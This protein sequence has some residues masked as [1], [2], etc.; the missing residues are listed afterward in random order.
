MGSQAES[1][2]RNDRSLNADVRP[3]S[4]ADT[5]RT[6][7]DAM[8]RG[9]LETYALIFADGARRW[10]AGVGETGVQESLDEMRGLSV[11]F[12]DFRLDTDALV[13][14]GDTVVAR[15][16]ARRGMHTAEFM[17]IPV[18]NVEIDIPVCEIYAFSDDGKVTQ[19]WM[20]SDPLAL[21]EAARRERPS[22]LTPAGLRAVSSPRVAIRSGTW[23]CQSVTCW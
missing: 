14:G 6:A 17:G 23:V 15:L 7:V 20:Y 4:N 5:I 9:D 12:P 19:T 11:G 16:A 10:T 8:N 18:T 3:V 21:A 22:R 2:A 13:D 1:R